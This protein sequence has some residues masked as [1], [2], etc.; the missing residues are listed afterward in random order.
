MYTALQPITPTL[1]HLILMYEFNLYLFHPSVIPTIDDNEIERYW[2][3]VF[4]RLLI[5][6]QKSAWQSV[7]LG[8]D[9]IYTHGQNL[10]K[11]LAVLFLA[12]SNV[13]CA[14]AV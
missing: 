11:F 13:V 4:W 9:T 14:Y 3:S 10:T 6:Q 8:P 7:G 5:L 1:I 2:S 12:L